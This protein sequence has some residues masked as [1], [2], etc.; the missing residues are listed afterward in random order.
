M[1]IFLY[2]WAL[3]ATLTQ[4]ALAFSN[5]QLFQTDNLSPAKLLLRTTTNPENGAWKSDPRVLRRPPTVPIPSLTKATHT[6]TR[7]RNKFKRSTVPNAA[8]AVS[9]HVPL[10]LRPRITPA[11]SVAGVLLICLGAAYLLIGIKFRWVLIPVGVFFL[12]DVAV[13]VLLAYVA[14]PPI[15][16]S[17][18][19]AYFAAIIGAALALGAA[20]WLFKEITEGLVCLLGGYCFSMWILVLRPGSSIHTSGAR[21]IFIVVISLAAY[22]LWFSRYTRDYGLIACSSFAGA[23][24][25]S[26]GIDCFSKAGLKEFWL[27]IWALNGKIFPFDTNNY[28]L[29]KGLRIEIA[30]IILAG[31]AGIMSQMRLWL[32]LKERRKHERADFLQFLL[33]V[34]R[35]RKESTSTNRQN[36]P[37]RFASWRMLL[38]SRRQR[39]NTR[40]PLDTEEPLEPGLPRYTEHS[41]LSR[42][43]ADELEMR[44]FSAFTLPPLG[45]SL[46]GVTSSRSP[47]SRVQDEENLFSHP[48]QVPDG[49][50]ENETTSPPRHSANRNT[51]NRSP[52]T[53]HVAENL[54][55]T[56]SRPIVKR[57]PLRQVASRSIDSSTEPLPPPQHT[58]PSRQETESVYATPESEREESVKPSPSDSPSV[59]ESRASIGQTSEDTNECRIQETA[60]LLSQEVPDDGKVQDA[61]Q[62]ASP[63]PRIASSR[64][65]RLREPTKRRSRDSENLT[66]YHVLP[67]SDQQLSPTEITTSTQDAGASGV[68][69]DNSRSHKEPF[70]SRPPIKTQNSRNRSIAASSDLMRTSIDENSETDFESLKGSHT[71]GAAVAIHPPPQPPEKSSKRHTLS[72]LR[73]SSISASERLRQLRDTSSSRSSSDNSLTSFVTRSE[74]LGNR[75]L[76]SSSEGAHWQPLSQTADDGDSAVAGRRASSD[77]PSQYSQPS[78]YPSPL[79]PSAS[80]P[81]MTPHNTAQR[82]SFTTPFPSAAQRQ[83]DLLATWRNSLHHDPAINVNLHN[84]TP[85]SYSTSNANTRRVEMLMDKH[86]DQLH[87]LQRQAAAIQRERVY[88]QVMRSREMQTAHREA[89]QRMQGE[90]NKHL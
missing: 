60:G 5:P 67:D 66:T 61:M 2:R 71:R 84:L 63:R 31:M 3:L 14:N 78:L 16:D 38:G 86:Q 73:E 89:L 45:D 37:Q 46:R 18:Q 81:I 30:V 21:A 27:Y 33:D 20:S 69:V 17:L 7:Q 44:F 59:N 42:S 54:T 64:N 32:F 25:L 6:P 57:K 50:R 87:Q 4:C 72:V 82:R 24:A 1:R 90:A 39:R 22:A 9:T 76:R 79:S 15:S 34:R 83:A 53:R 23:T 85:T 28:P 26:L 48:Q 52:I 43:V 56:T 19:G 58:E 62:H 68:S 10:P 36:Q 40:F 41:Q 55:P 70:H 51:E 77:S 47:R 13:C 12:I 8:S 74:P 35:S 75:S 11:T 49:Y 65:H 80:G 29:S 88:D